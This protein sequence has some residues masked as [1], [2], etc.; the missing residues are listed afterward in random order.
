MQWKLS[1]EDGEVYLHFHGKKLG[2]PSYVEPDLQF[3]GETEELFTA[4]SL[5]GHL[6]DEGRLVL[7]RRLLREGFLTVERAS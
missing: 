1:E 4:R 6:D 2:T 7:I 5:P 3:I